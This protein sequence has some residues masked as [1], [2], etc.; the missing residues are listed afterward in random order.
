MNVSQQNIL[1]GGFIP[2]Y[3]YVA[4]KRFDIYSEYKGKSPELCHKIQYS[5]LNQKKNPNLC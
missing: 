2:S 5:T 3:D 4:V 1:S